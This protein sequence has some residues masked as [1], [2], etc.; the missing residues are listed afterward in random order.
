MRKQKS[1]HDE[2]KRVSI[3][4]VCPSSSGTIHAI[5]QGFQEELAK[6]PYLQCSYTV[7]DHGGDNTLL[8]SYIL[9]EVMH[10]N[11]D[12]VFT[13]GQITTN[14]TA[15]MMKQNK[16]H[17]PMVFAAVKDPV[18]AG[19]VP[20]E[21]NH[22]CFITGSAVDPSEQYE[23]GF[24]LLLL[25]KSD[26]K[27]LLIPYTLHQ[28]DSVS[29]R[30]IADAE[31]YMLKQGIAVQKI[32]ISSVGECMEK[33]RTFV[34]EGDVVWIYR[35]AAV[36]ANIGG[37]SKL[38]AQRGA[39]VYSSS[40]G[41]IAQGAAL[42][43]CADD[44]GSGINAGKKARE[45]LVNGKHPADVPITPAPYHPYL[46]INKKFLKL[47]KF[48]IDPRVL[49]LIENAGIAEGHSFAGNGDEV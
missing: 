16:S 22:S 39:M 23:Q 6:E 32:E 46:W 15:T 1:Q 8:R 25:L 20:Q 18:G 14:L 26:I 49:F 4:L 10:K 43:F 38:A 31:A 47:G 40:F 11:F 7:Y 17:T 2:V 28:F 48:R 44:K 42:S 45:I 41:S 35:D 19:I 37:I 30:D 34:Q 24:A 27:R 21:R 9:D 33:M 13:I 29:R 36:M 3:A 5:F 12:L